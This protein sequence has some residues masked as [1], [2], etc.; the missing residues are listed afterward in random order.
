MDVQ[1]RL[2]NDIVAGELPFGARLRIE[3]LA[4]RYGVSHMPVREALRILHGEGLVVIEPNR[5]ARVRPIYR[6]FIE[7]M[8][9]IR[10]S[11]ETMLAR[12]AAERRTA[13][14]LASLREAAS[15]LE[16]CVA[17]GDYEGVPVA[18]REF[19]SVIN[20][21][22]GNLAAL[23][24]VDSHWLMLSALLKRYGYGEERFAR[25]ID[26]HQHLITAIEQRDAQ[27]AALLMG[28]H[29]E[30]GKHNLLARAAADPRLAQPATASG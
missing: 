7:D 6:G 4:V 15:R 9:D 18:N 24:I 12:R 2:R 23:A 27:G 10:T 21:A 11:I 29:I 20:A 26:E 19:H 5:G 25:V 13:Q 1:Q 17:R 30:R 3:E 8:F 22:A 28:A 16:S 14:H